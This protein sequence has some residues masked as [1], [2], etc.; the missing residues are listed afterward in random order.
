MSPPAPFAPSLKAR[1]A[2]GPDLAS[3]PTRSAATNCGDSFSPG[4]DAC[5]VRAPVATSTETMRD[6][7]RAWPPRPR[8]R[9]VSSTASS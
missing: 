7:T 9:N 3:Q 4:P 2:A 5:S 8:A 1:V 6:S